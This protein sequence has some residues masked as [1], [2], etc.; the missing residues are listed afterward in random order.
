MISGACNAKR[1]EILRVLFLTK[2]PR[3]G[4]SSRY[5]VLQFIPYL[6][7]NGIECSV[8][9]LHAEG[10]ID[11]LY[12]GRKR[13][14]VYHLRRFLRRVAVVL[15][16]KRYS[17]VFIQKELIPY[18]P[19]FCELFLRLFGAKII[20]DID[21][22]IF[23]F[24]TQASSRFTRALLGRKIPRVIGLSDAVL[25]GN[26]YLRDYAD[27]YSDRALLFPTV[28]D[29]SRYSV[30]YDDRS[31]GGGGVAG[32]AAPLIGWIGSPETLDYLRVAEPVLKR[33]A[34]N[35]GAGLL[36]IGVPGFSIDGIEV[37][38]V[39]WSEETEADELRRCDIGIMPLPR[40]EWARGKC[41]LK[42][43]QY[44]AAGLPVVSSPDGGASDIITHGVTGFIAHSDEQ[45]EAY[46]TELLKNHPLRR[47]LGYAARRWVEQR[48]SIDVWA[49][50]MAEIVTKVAGGIAVEDD[51][52]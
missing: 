36:V 48:Y 4:P 44:M 32:T 12:A 18:A 7:R 29:P 33:A 26:A 8:Q 5:R 52:W 11:G 50:R 21:D 3:R 31:D 16:A 42:V 38:A 22:A 49:P 35:L 15:N 39:P 28:I 47:R 25:A 17:V 45:W 1:R 10:Y 34:E 40:T 43:L 19:P 30:R 41:G 9:S 2:Y 13:S 6:E 24:Y 23:L 14:P 20:Y 46:L 51:S 37:E 27:R